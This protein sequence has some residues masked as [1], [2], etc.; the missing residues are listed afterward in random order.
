MLLLALLAG[1]ATT[2]A[3]D[4]VPRAAWGWT[5]SGARLP[6][7]TIKR[8]TIHHGGVAF[9]DDRDP[10]EYL[11]ALQKWSR[12]EKQWMDIPYH[13]VIDLDGVI[14]EARPI[15]YPGD[16]NTTYDTRSH[17]LI[18]VLGNYDERQLNDAQF[19]ALARLSALLSTRYSVAPEDIRTH[20]DYAPGE[21]TC[22]GASIYRRFEDGSLP[23]R[24]GELL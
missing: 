8:I 21:T 20:R 5:D 18:E 10:A 4:I 13:Y 23:R 11:R 24:I 3:P 14:Y 1:C 7:H 22:P 17:A 9:A 15:E 16:T 12:T 6:E 19:E 2:N